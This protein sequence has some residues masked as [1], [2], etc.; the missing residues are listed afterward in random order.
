VSSG[1]LADARPVQ[2]SDRLRTARWDNQGWSCRRTV[3]STRVERKCDSTAGPTNIAC[4]Q[5][6]LIWLPFAYFDD[7]FATSLGSGNALGDR[8]GICGK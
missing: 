1:L 2:L 6:R 5:A 7:V 8:T 4:S 3:T